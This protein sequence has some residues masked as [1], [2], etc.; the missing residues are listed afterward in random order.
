MSVPKERL[1][2][3]TNCGMAPMRRDI[4]LRKL[5]AL[6]QGA[7]LARRPTPERRCAA[8]RVSFA[9]AGWLFLGRSRG[10]GW[11]AGVLFLE[12]ADRS[13]QRTKRQCGALVA[14]GNDGDGTERHGCL[15]V[16]KV[17]NGASASKCAARTVDPATS[18]VAAACRYPAYARVGS[19]QGPW[20][21]SGK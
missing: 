7:A 1:L 8:G 3:C 6:A 18:L 16:V 21:R 20:P 4:A 5:E 9:L 2:A 17:R 10:C 12:V 19:T 14:A 11:F 15:R 13:F